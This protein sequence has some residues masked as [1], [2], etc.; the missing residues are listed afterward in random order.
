[1]NLNFY[2]AGMNFYFVLN[3]FVIW[4]LFIYRNNPSNRINI[5]RLLGNPDLAKFIIIAKP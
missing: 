5:P 2:K 1:M 4:N 3:F